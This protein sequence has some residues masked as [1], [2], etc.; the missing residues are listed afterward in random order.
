[1]P[2]RTAEGGAFV[3]T[4]SPARSVT[5]GETG[6]YSSCTGQQCLG[7]PGENTPT[8]TYGTATG[9]GPFRCASTPTGVTCVAAG[10][11]FRISTSGITSVFVHGTRA[12]MAGATARL[13]LGPPGGWS[14]RG[15]PAVR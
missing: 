10:R 12:F 11:G 14:R 13:A 7:N 6:T 4:V 15:L 2:M 1:M 8:L 9:V 5:M 3:Q